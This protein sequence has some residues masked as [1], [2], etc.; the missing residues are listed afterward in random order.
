ME[1]FDGRVVGKM[2]D[3]GAANTT[4]RTDNGSVETAPETRQKRRR[5]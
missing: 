1:A 4:G 2:L 5:V 3:E